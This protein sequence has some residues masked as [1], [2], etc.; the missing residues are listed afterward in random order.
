MALGFNII[1]T[2]PEQQA[3]DAK[4]REQF[5]PIISYVET[6]HKEKQRYPSN[7]EF[8]IWKNNHGMENRANF[9]YIGIL[10]SDS[11]FDNQLK[12][13]KKYIISIWRGGWNAFYIAQEN[14]FYPGDWGYDSA[15]IHFLFS[16]LISAFFFICAWLLNCKPKAPNKVIE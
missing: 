14:R 2:T 15:F 4:F 9:L 8:E 1:T 11:D 10:P 3:S 7:E 13:N 16:E 5:T 6:F 12:E